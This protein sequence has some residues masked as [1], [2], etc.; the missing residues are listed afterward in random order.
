MTVSSVKGGCRP[1]WVSL[2]CEH[3]VFQSPR[4][5]VP[6]PSADG[7]AVLAELDSYN[8]GDAVVVTFQTGPSSEQRRVRNRYRKSKTDC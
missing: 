4:L 7:I 5:A 3:N 2:Q 8:D 6:I 1:G